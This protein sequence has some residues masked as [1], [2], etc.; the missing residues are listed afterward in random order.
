MTAPT[1]TPD[2]LPPGLAFLAGGGSA[3][4]LILAR[5]WRDHPLGPPEHWPAPFKVAL[6]LLLNSPESM[7]L[8]WG[9]EDLFFFFNETYFP[10]LGPRLDRAMGAP[11]REV[12]A[13]AWQQAQPI[14]T[15]AF[16]GRSQRFVDLPWKLDTDRGAAET[17]WSFSYSRVLG[18]DGAIV[19]LFIFTNE[20][21]QSVLAH[22]A[23]IASRAE[24]EHLN[25]DLSRQ[26][27]AR[28]AE[29]DRMWVASPDLMAIV[30]HDGYYSAV[31]PAWTEI[32][33]YATDELVGHHALDLIHPVDMASTS[34]AMVNA[35][36]G[37]MPTF[38][39]RL[40]HKDGG[41]RWLQWVAA[42]GADE[43]FAVGRHVTDAKEAEAQLRTA[44]EQ[45]HQAQKME[46]IGQL[47]G[48]VAH[49]FNNLLT[50]IRGSVELLRRPGL[51][52]T[53]RDRYIEAIGDTA[54]R[55]AKLTGQLLAF[56]R[57]QALTP[58]LIDVGHAVGGIAEMIQTLIGAR[59]TLKLDI[60]AERC[61]TE[62]DRS[63]FETA[64]VNL[65]IN[66]RDAMEGHGTLRIAVSPVRA[67][68]SLR[69]HHGVE[70]DFLSVSVA[71]DGTGIAADALP[72]IF[73][74]FFTTKGVGKGT[75]L[76]LSQVIGFAK[77]SGGDISVDSPPDGGTTFTL[78][79]P[80]VAG[81][82]THS[83]TT[84]DDGPADGH[85]ACVLLVEDNDEVGRFAT[86][87]LDELGYRSIL[88]TNGAE[89]L[90]M[91]DADA[92][93]FDV[94]FSDVVMPGMN[95]VDLAKRL[96]A[97]HPKLP[98]VLTSGYA[99]V[100]AENA[101]HGFELL[102]KPYSIEQLSRILRRALGRSARWR[103]R[104]R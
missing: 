23:L 14:V 46:A 38:E 96:N 6:S 21:T 71:D 100:L 78:Y 26:V 37:T 99:H 64:I 72:H 91:L 36:A 85:G 25:A 84:E 44:T 24:L 28:T 90:A 53:K 8:C 68:P 65:A 86:T 13:D 51:P 54:E 2:D 32:L 12:W 81:D 48:G 42:A 95:G 80:R 63:Q 43:V 104:D 101:Q 18:V 76:G 39:N 102:H 5:D 17:W 74:P 103:D 9:A 70:G 35:Q 11:M 98:V 4:Q 33:G 47:T 66:A 45:L 83:G 30:S 3:T 19:G 62:I 15:D 97:D 75:G 93:R 50:I 22:R 16:A 69:G 77:Q 79:L 31:N 89:A 10:L 29:R 56:A 20:T 7:I 60:P 59:I 61:L 88:A 87:A 49:D 57:R 58:E 41:Y 67:I 92:A 34:A 52:A 73:E 94:V 1:P 27:T 40:R 55:A 82:T